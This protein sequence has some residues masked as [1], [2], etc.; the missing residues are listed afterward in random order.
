[1]KNKDK[2]K[3][4]PSYVDLM[5]FEGLVPVPVASFI[6][7]CMSVHGNVQLGPH[8]IFKDAMPSKIAAVKQY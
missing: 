4:R 3:M 1:M 5:S 6:T 7:S 8:S 2:M